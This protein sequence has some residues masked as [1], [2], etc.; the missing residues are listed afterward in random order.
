[1]ADIAAPESLEETN[2]LRVAAGLAPIG[3]GAENDEPEVDEDDLAEANFSQRRDEMRRARAETE[4]KER[5]AKAKNQRALNAKMKGGTL[6]DKNKDDSLD[7]KNWIKKQKKRAKERE[8]ELAARRVR[9]MEEADNAATYDEKD[10]E[11]LKVGHAE[12]EFET[13]QDVV[14]T[15]KDTR[16]LAGD[17]TLYVTPS[18]SFPANC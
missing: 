2:R 4:V 3:G 12:D 7:T 9:E 16:V 8:K 11:G 1:M 15:L 10:L 6:G 5:I 13:G 18:R 17:G 14:L